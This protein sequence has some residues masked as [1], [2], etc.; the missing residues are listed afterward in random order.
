MFRTLVIIWIVVL[1]IAALGL[2]G[3]Q[4]GSPANADVKAQ[5]RAA[6]GI[7]EAAAYGQF[8]SAEIN[9]SGVVGKF[10]TLSNSCSAMRVSQCD[11]DV[12]IAYYATSALI[13][14]LGSRPAPACLYQT[15]ASLIEALE[16][17]RSGLLIAGNG[18]KDLKVNA[19]TE[20]TVL[21]NAGAKLL[22]G[23]A[24]TITKAS[25]NAAQSC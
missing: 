11:T 14:R 20:G 24:D 5:L 13:E 21:M 16:T 19:I 23:T 12:W 6:S 9:N 18:I 1:C 22:N 17:L 4:N 15:R 25:R 2:V 10:K 7:E 3:H 8:I